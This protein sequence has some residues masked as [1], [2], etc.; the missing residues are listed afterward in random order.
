MISVQAGY[1]SR[2]SHLEESAYVFEYHVEIQNS[3]PDSVQLLSREWLIFDSLNLHSRIVG[4]G[5]VGEQPILSKGD[6]HHY[7]SYCEL[8]SDIGYMEGHYIFENLK[9]GHRFR[10][11]IPRFY[12]YFPGK[13]N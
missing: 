10:V 3:N 13:L 12:L 5:V 1:N 11:A 8:K 2:L 4:E 7:T 6:N 9:T